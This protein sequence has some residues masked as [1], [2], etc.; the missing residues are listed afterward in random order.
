MPGTFFNPMRSAPHIHLPK[1]GV[2]RRKTPRPER[3]TM[4]GGLVDRGVMFPRF[5]GRELGQ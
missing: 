2:L 1:E 4:A 3:S 5:P